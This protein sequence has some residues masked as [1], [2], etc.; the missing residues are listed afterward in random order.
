M[1]LAHLDPAL[2]I[3]LKVPQLLIP[4]KLVLLDQVPVKLTQRHHR[5]KTQK[6]AFLDQALQK[7]AQNSLPLKSAVPLL[8]PPEL[9]LLTLA[10]KIKLQLALK[11][12]ILATL[13]KLACLFNFQWK[14]LVFLARDFPIPNLSL[15]KS[16]PLLQPPPI[17]LG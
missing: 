13:L 3:F 5:P 16:I 14:C 10:L 2:Q 12:E 6:L 15:G 7:L 11:L 4:Q 17:G 1:K 8:I 9:A